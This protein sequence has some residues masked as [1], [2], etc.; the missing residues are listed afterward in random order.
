MPMMVERDGYECIVTFLW[1][2]SLRINGFDPVKL[3][4]D[5]YNEGKCLYDKRGV[6]IFG[7]KRG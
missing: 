1:E 2:P 5:L 4:K 3:A 7:F 6:E